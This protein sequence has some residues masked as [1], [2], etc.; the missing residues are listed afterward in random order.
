MSFREY[1]GSIDDYLGDDDD[2]LGAPARRRA[3]ARGRNAFVPR[4]PPRQVAAA[5]TPVMPGVPKEGARIEP[6]GFEAFA[7][8]AASGT[9]LSKT[10]RP[11]KPFKGSRLVLDIARTGAT[12]TGLVTVT[13]F[14]V[15][16]RN[17]LVNSQPIG[18]GTFAP[19]GVGIQLM[20]DEVTPGV[21][22][23]LQLA[24]SAAPGAS[25]RVDIA[26]TLIGLTWS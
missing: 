15:G 21:E 19:D 9:S 18:A 12:S 14:V 24:I 22:I 25:D 26:A 17:V 2:I 6:L 4:V 23:T 20:L 10:T 5:L 16:A 11:M 7:F 8:T 13:Q 3:P 1:L